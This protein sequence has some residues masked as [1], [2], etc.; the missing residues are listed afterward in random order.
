MARTDICHH[1]RR[2]QLWIA[3]KPTIGGERTFQQQLN[4][5]DNLN[6]NRIYSIVKL[7]YLVFSIIVQFDKLSAFHLL[8]LW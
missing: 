5:W 3:H 7:N 4:P 1:L 2:P 6:I 8:K